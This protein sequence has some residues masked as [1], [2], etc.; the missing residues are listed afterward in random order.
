MGQLI[1]CTGDQVLNI[2]PIKSTQ[3]DEVVT[4]FDNLH[5][6]NVCKN[7]FNTI[8]ISIQDFY[9]NLLDFNDP[10]STVILKL[11]FKKF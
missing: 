9:G 3:D 2:I 6:V 4:F 10:F 5:Y 1:R 11:H 8:N 7:T